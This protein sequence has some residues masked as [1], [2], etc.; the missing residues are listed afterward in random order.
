MKYLPASPDLAHLRKQAKQL[1]RDARA[2]DAEATGR[3][4]ATLP[5]A[6]DIDLA[7]YVPRLHDAQSVVAREYGF[8]S[9]TELK[10]Y[11]EWK[12]IDTAERLKHW[13][14]WCFEGNARERRLA[15][16]LL[17]EEP[18]LFAHDPWF[19]C[20]IGEEARLRDAVLGNPGFV[21]RPGGPI[22]MLPLVAVTHSKLILEEGAEPRFL[23]CARLLLDHGA[24]PN[25]NWI[26]P[27]WPDHPLSALYGAA[28]R[29]HSMRMTELLLTA[30]ASPNDN[31][32][33]YHS[34]EARD[35]A[36]TRLLLAA[37]ARVSGTNALGRVLD[38]DKLDSLERM[39]AQEPAAA[40]EHP[41]VHHAILRGR[42]LEHVKALLEAGADPRALD[43]DGTSLY[44]FAARMG[45]QDLLGLLRG[46]GVEDHLG[47]EEAFVAACS[48]ADQ[49]A[50]RL[51]LQRLP[52]IFARLT[53]KQLQTMPELAAIGRIDAVRT[54]LD[55]GWPREVK[56]GWDA[57]ALNHAVFQGDTELAR[58]LLEAGA[59]WCTPH[60]FDSNV[61]GTLSFA[62]Q[63]DDIA[64]PAPRD[65]LGCAKLLV[66]H[67]IPRSEF[68]K[69]GFS[70]EIN[71]YFAVI[72]EE[73]SR[74]G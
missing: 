57:T 36:C 17:A 62:S 56:A 37:G 26:D 31:E 38:F 74:S 47:D 21:S 18:A 55:L 48:R 32:S 29:S 65:Y 49:P 45:R 24:D 30:G 71:A 73:R 35:P 72:E 8:A 9:W 27:R 1:L 67:G 6:R 50:A 58:L 46:L 13:L 22:A 3:F 68:D 5:V 4:L 60:G 12:R 14:N 44:R 69:H 41:W 25:A 20:L 64:D 42:S 34:T 11:V 40:S 70:A 51:I 63:A 52:D 16:R 39:L 66:A 54:M 7:T 10:R 23:A 33:L 59:D 28:G 15:L 43:R 19:A 61:V 2:G 53:E